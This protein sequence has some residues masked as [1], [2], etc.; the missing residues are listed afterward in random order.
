MRSMA[1]TVP[2]VW[3]S[4]GKEESP[5]LAIIDSR[6]VKTS[7][8]VDTDRGIDGNK[9]IKGRKEHIV[10]DTLGLPM[11]I[12]VHEANIHD[13]KGAKPTIENL[14][15]KFPRLSKILAD[16]GYQG[17]LAAWVKD[18][19]GWEMEVVLR[20][21]ESSK[22]FNVIPKRWIVERTFSWLENYRRLTI[23]YEFLTETAETMV[24]IAFIQIALNRFF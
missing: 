10:V 2:L 20:T 11:A 13:S 5:S 9:K 23:D 8:H 3:K 1:F 17:D 4:V 18:K 12:K 19:F 14:A 16:G 15:Y 7:H 24:S 22:K 21:K 6:S